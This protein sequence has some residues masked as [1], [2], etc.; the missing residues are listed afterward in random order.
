MNER[1]NEFKARIEQLKEKIKTCSQDEEEHIRKEIE[2]LYSQIADLSKSM[3]QAQEDLKDITQEFT[4]HSSTKTE[5][6]KFYSFVKSQTSATLD[7]ATYLDRAWNLICMEKYDDAIE[8]LKKVLGI[9]PKN[10]KGLGFMGFTFMNKKLYDNA[11]LYF[12]K[13][14]VIEPDNPFALNNLGY[15]CFKK[16]IWGEAIEHLT[17]AAK[18]TKDR[19]AALY[20]NYYLGLVYYERGMFNDA[21]KFFEAAVTSG[22]NLQEAYYY[23]GLSE[24]KQ[25]EFTKAVSYYEKCIKIDPQSRYGSLAKEEM[26]KIKPLIEPKI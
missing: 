22:P 26:A 9:D 20:A 16:G 13:V 4:Q 7:I 12:Q 5:V 17:K 2:Q 18:Q 1:L 21:I 3:M 6:E 8:V 10:V 25:Y 19:M 23:L 24:T 11:M 15:I 14:L